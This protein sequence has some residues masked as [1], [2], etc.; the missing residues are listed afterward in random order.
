M[1]YLTPT[2]NAVIVIGLLCALLL[3]AVWSDVK[4]HRIP[5]WLVLAG[6][7]LGLLLNSVLPLGYGFVS[8][9]TG[10]LGF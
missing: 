5:N 9:L 1:D 4:S 2:L 7:G 8:S 3:V 10:A 6:A